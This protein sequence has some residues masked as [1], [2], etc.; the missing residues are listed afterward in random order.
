MYYHS[1]NNSALKIMTVA[2]YVKFDI[3]AL[4]QHISYY[5]ILLTLAIT[6]LKKG[7]KNFQVDQYCAYKIMMAQIRLNM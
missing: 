6:E 2:L 5:L 7:Q 1:F 3:F 4:P